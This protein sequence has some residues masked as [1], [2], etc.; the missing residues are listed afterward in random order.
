M[1]TKYT[2][3]AHID[4]YEIIESGGVC[5]GATPTIDWAITLPF[6][7]VREYCKRKGWVVVPEQTQEPASTVFEFRG[8]T[9]EI[10]Y[11]GSLMH[12]TR[13]EEEIRWQDLP[14]QLKGLL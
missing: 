14:E 4:R 3:R 10:W 2:V 9:Y 7:Y 1:P 8:A 5:I 13:D 6:E 12:I 11:T